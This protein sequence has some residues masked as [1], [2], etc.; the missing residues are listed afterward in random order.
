MSTAEKLLEDQNNS[1]FSCIN[2]LNVLGEEYHKKYE[3]IFKPIEN[4]DDEAWLVHN[5]VADKNITE[6][7]RGC[8]ENCYSI[9]DEIRETMLCLFGE[10]IDCGDIEL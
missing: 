2:V 1:Q 7:V 8:Y 6:Y 10:I 5:L 4:E 3:Y 9:I